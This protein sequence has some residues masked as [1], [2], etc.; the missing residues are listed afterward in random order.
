[1]TWWRYLH[2]AVGRHRIEV[3]QHHAVDVISL[4]IAGFSFIAVIVVGWMTL[5]WAQHDY[6]VRRKEAV[7]DVVLEMRTLYSEQWVANGGR[8]VEPDPQK[9]AGVARDNLRRKLGARLALFPDRLRTYE[10]IHKLADNPKEHWTVEFLKDAVDE[11]VALV[12][13]EVKEPRMA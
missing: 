6:Q 10:L 13:T 3:W 8:Y 5:R 7:L 12:R 1:M 11:G 2:S 9:P 4:I